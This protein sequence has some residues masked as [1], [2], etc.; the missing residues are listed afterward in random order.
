MTFKQVID[1][2]ENEWASVHSSFNSEYSLYKQFKRDLLDDDLDSEHR[3][4]ILE[5]IREHALSCNRAYSNMSELKETVRTFSKF[6]T[7]ENEVNDLLNLFNRLDDIV[8]YDYDKVSF[9][10]QHENLY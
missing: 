7:K 5:S 9:V 6:A 10:R 8:W 1:G 2:F 4:M 3:S